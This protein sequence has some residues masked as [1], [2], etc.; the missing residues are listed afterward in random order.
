MQGLHKTKNAAI[1][2]YK[3]ELD[4]INQFDAENFLKY[5]SF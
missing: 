1:M 2:R 3:Q 5:T 4:D